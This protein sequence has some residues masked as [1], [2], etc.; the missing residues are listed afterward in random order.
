MTLA[1]VVLA[2]VVAVL[3]VLVAGLLRSHAL[4][5]RQLHQAGLG[6]DS[7][8][9]TS[10]TLPMAG[11]GAGHDEAAEA[12][13]RTPR[14]GDAPA[15][16]RAQDVA[17][18]TPEGGSAGVAVRD[19]DHDTVLLFLSSD[20][21]TCQRF[22]AALDPQAGQRPAL[23]EGVRLVVVTRGVE[24]ELPAAVA[25][26][27]VDVPVIM[28]DEA[29]A[30]YD[31]PGSPYAIHVDGPAGRVRGEGTGGDWAQV[32]QLLA[33]A[34]GDMAYVGASP[35]RRRK[36]RRDREVERD[37]DAELLAAGIL[38]GDESLYRRADGSWVGPPDEDDDA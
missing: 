10:S 24:H 30:D 12:A 3:V 5:L 8:D 20:C 33:R 15:G 14:P 11:D 26:H 22:W 23:P 34:T 1:V 9:G 36:A 18:Q 28:S 38:P 31:V 13:E 7:F 29:W 17:G 16:R 6:L 21:A 35:S 27:T 4:I 2:I 25:E 32:A 37:T 19:V